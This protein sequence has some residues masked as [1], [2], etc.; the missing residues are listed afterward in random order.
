MDSCEKEAKLKHEKKIDDQFTNVI[1][2]IMTCLDSMVLSLG[3]DGMNVKEFIKTDNGKQILNMYANKYECSLS[4]VTRV[5]EKNVEQRIKNR[6]TDSVSHGEQSN[7][8][9]SNAQQSNAQQSNALQSNA[10]QSNA[11]QS[12]ALQ[13]NAQ[14]SNAQQSNALQSNTLQSNALQS[15]AQQSNAQQLNALQSNAQQSN[16]Q[17]SVS[18]Q[19][20][21]QHPTTND[22]TFNA[23]ESQTGSS[24][25]DSTVQVSG[26]NSN[27]E[28]DNNGIEITAFNKASTDLTLQDVDKSR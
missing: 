21:A 17:E 20:N 1:S 22:Q 16:A 7:A 5:V 4:D 9:Q 15:N 19:L 12:N 27:N 2:Y 28:G 3:T 18:Q 10:L 11:L 26:Q 6:D 24:P 14:Q 13:S 8:Q 23:R 25:F